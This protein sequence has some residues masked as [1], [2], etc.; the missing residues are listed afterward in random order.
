MLIVQDTLW[1]ILLAADDFPE[2]FFALTD[3]LRNHFFRLV[4]FNMTVEGVV[5]AWLCST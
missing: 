1:H 4:M 5:F 2:H 3:D